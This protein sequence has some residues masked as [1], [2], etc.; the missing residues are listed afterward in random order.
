LAI[1]A[2]IQRIWPLF[3]LWERA[4]PRLFCVLAV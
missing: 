4:F 2:R 1:N 3:F